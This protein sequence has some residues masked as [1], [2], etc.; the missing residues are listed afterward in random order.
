MLQ[1]ES[2]QA[3]RDAGLSF[4]EFSYMLLQAFDFLQ[5]FRRQGCTLQVGGSDQWGN[6]TA[7]VDLIRKVEGAE[8]HGLVAPLVTTAS[9][10]KFGKS[11]SDA[12]YL[13]PALTSPYKFYQ[14]WFNSDDRDMESHLRLFT[15][16]PKDGIRAI[17]EAHKKNPGARAAQ[18]KLA[19]E[20]T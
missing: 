1:K 10:A 19:S 7:G 14:Y 16:L 3:R 4:T 18:V 5:L 15:L 17:C 9:G 8:A 13:D 12:I 11:E 2:V 6:I 20:V